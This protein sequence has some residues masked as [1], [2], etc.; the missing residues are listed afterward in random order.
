M[1]SYIAASVGADASPG[2]L[3]AD[4]QQAQELALVLSQLEVALAHRC[5][6]LDDR[7]ADVLLEL[8]VPGVGVLGLDLAGRL[9]RRDRED[10]D[11]VRDARLVVA[12]PDL[13]VRSRSRRS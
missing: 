10:V 11:Q 5:H 9:P 4:G 3:G 2:S 8:A 13:P 1:R 7:L 12:A 6:Q